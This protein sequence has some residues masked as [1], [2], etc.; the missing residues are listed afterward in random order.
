MREARD[1]GEYIRTNRHRMRYA[2]FHA[3]GLWT[4]SA[5]GESGCKRAIGLRLKQG[6][7]FWSVPGAN[8]I[9]ALRCFRLSGRFEAFWERR[10]DRSAA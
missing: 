6:G 3:A 8:A 4:S 7:M 9:I 1:C 5:V 2:Q 10:A